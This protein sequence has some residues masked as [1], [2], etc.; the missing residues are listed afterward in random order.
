MRH[1]TDDP[2][3][4]VW[5]RRLTAL[6]V[7]LAVGHLG[8]GWY[9]SNQI[10]SG[11][12]EIVN[13]SETS[14]DLLIKDV[15]N[16]A[17]EI[18]AG[19]DADVRSPGTWGVSWPGGN[20]VVGEIISVTDNSVVREFSIES[21]LPSIEAFVNIEPFAYAGTPRTA[22]ELEFEEITFVSPLGRL[23]AWH[24]PTEGKKWVIFVHGKS[25]TRSESLR[26]IPALH[27][28][29]FDVVAID[30]RNDPGAPIDP[31]GFH[32]Q[33]LTEWEDLA[34]AV[35]YVSA[36][37]AE[38][39]FIFGS[40]MGGGITANYLLEAPNADRVDAVVLDSPVLNFEATV[41][42]QADQFHVPGS[43][44]NAAKA[45][46]SWRFGV[47]W[48]ATDYTAS[49]DEYNTP[50]LIFHGAKDTSVPIGPSR[51]LAQARPDLV[52][53][54]ESPGAAHVRSWNADPGQYELALIDF[55]TLA[56]R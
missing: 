38:S 30:Y 34:A 55:L 22:H 20:G 6:L 51:E 53:L 17:I 15:S 13:P 4:P 46:A 11:A 42:S 27:Q 16:Q 29:N 14:Y 25:G 35:D 19:D 39:I 21:E 54:I 31:S 45:L 9:F 52:S 43:I 10:R 49:P 28:A 36:A 26:M 56:A 7:V 18:V 12:L 24:I 33:G 40:S 44:R 2:L 5:L 47:D 23:G 41:D 48:S 32:R 8:T 1:G 37:G 50:M 3:R